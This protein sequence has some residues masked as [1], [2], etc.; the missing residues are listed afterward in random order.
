MNRCSEPLL[1][2]CSSCSHPFHLEEWQGHSR[3]CPVCSGK[4]GVW[5][6]GKCRGEFDQPSLGSEHPCLAENNLANKSALGSPDQTD[7][8]AFP[9]SKSEL[10][11][12]WQMGKRKQPSA[13][14]AEKENNRLVP[15]QDINQPRGV[16]RYFSTKGRANRREIWLVALSTPFLL[17]AVF[18]L[19]LILFGFL[20]FSELISFELSKVLFMPFFYLTGFPLVV[21]LNI[22][23][24]I[25]RLHDVGESN[26]WKL[27]GYYNIYLFFKKGESTT[28][29]H[30]PPQ[31]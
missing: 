10:S 21:W 28:N 8:V 23:V 25:R 19:D 14:F 7:R 30:G 29:A 4:L 11:Q 2:F 22:A 3:T 26:I 5:R 1:W 17:S 12:K 16:W 13:L 6:C 18:F 24:S 31:K 20:I 9:L 15:T 27:N